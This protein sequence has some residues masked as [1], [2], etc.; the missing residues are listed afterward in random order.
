MSADFGLAL[1]PTSVDLDELVR[2]LKKASDSV[3]PPQGSN[4]Q[5]SYLQNTHQGNAGPSSTSTVAEFGQAE[6]GSKAPLAPLAVTPIDI[7]VVAASVQ[8]KPSDNTVVATLGSGNATAGNSFTYTLA[9]DP[10]GKF[11]V[12]GNEVRLKAGASVDYEAAPSYDLTV[13]ITDTEGLSRVETLTIE[14]TGRSGST[15]STSGNNALTGSS[16]G[17]ATIDGAIDNIYVVDSVDDVVTELAGQGTDTV[18]SSISY[19]LGANVE[20]LQLTGTANINATG[21]TGNNTLT[22]NAGNNVLNGGTGNDTMSGGAGNDTM[23]GGAGHDVFVYMQGNGSDTVNGGAGAGWID[24]VQLDQSLGS[25]QPGADWTVT[26]TSGNI[27]GQSA[28]ELTFSADAD[29]T[30]NFADGSQM[31]FT[32]MERVQW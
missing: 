16:E 2:S 29:G 27:V 1:P 5:D 26:L 17:G 30:I 4:Q 22:G 10:S 3:A 8:E 12:V 24:T 21:N 18:Q 28:S 9:D 7:T 19:A 11:E 23:T 32:D 6:D 20:N 25:Q 13:T 14:I 15:A 31:T